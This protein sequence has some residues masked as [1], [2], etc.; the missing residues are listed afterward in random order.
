MPEEQRTALRSA[1]RWQIFTIVYTACTIT[2]IAFVMGDSRAMQTAWIEDMLSLLPQL[3]FLAALPFVRRCPSR[4]HP[5]GWH[6]AMGV[7][8]LLA[9]AALLGVGLNLALDAAGD[10]IAGVVTGTVSRSVMSKCSV[11]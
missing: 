9:G 11:T 7:G 10:L 1:V 2:I 4:E 3:S 5:Y 8:H 6:R